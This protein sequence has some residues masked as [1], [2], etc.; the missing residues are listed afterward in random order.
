MERRVHNEDIANVKVKGKVDKRYIPYITSCADLNIVH[1][2]STRLLRFGISANKIFDYAASEKP[3]LV[4]YPSKYNPAIEMEAGIEIEKQT[5]EKIARAIETFCCME[6]EQYIIYCENAKKV[7]LKY[8]F[9]EL[10][11]QLLHVIEY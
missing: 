10:T 1:G 9:R 7:A 3:L 8:D 11:K 5:P 6:K 4:D 2:H